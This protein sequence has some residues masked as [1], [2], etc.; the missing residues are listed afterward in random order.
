[1]YGKVA[2]SPVRYGERQRPEH[3]SGDLLIDA[4]VADAPRTV[5]LAV[6][7]ARLQTAIDRLVNAR[8]GLRARVVTRASF[9]I[10]LLIRE[11]HKQGD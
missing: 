4:Q 9:L 1:M 10:G 8:M 2:R 3:R 7:Y 5:P 11:S 6:P